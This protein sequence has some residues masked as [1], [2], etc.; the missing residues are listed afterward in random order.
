M[1]VT[2]CFLLPRVGS[3]CVV[4]LCQMWCLAGAREVSRRSV[5]RDV[6]VIRLG[7]HRIDLSPSTGHVVGVRF[8]IS[9]LADRPDLAQA[10]WN[11]LVAGVHVSRPDRRRP[12]PDSSLPKLLG[13][14]PWCWHD[15]HPSVKG[16]PPSDPVRDTPD[17][18]SSRS[19]PT[20]GTKDCYA[21]TSCRGGERC[22]SPRL[23]TPTS[24]HGWPSCRP[25]ASLA[26]ASVR[27]TGRSP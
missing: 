2:S 17:R 15:S 20:S 24:H 13:L 8:T 12:N 21:G 10:M 11:M 5:M 9:L 27:R 7:H 4:R 3:D 23:D 6:R 1:T 22:R 14:L 25:A 16:K 19:R 18:C 26:Q